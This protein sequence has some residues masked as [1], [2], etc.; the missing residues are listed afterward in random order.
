MNQALAKRFK[1]VEVSDNSN[2][3]GLKGHIL[4][5]PDGET[6]EAGKTTQFAHRVG[7]IV[8]LAKSGDGDF[9]WAYKGFEIPSLIGKA[10]NELVS[11]FWP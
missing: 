4:M 11:K 7:E 6:W 8:T 5:A 9:N 1:V 2:S 10:P 3:F